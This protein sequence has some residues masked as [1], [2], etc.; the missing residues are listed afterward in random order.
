MPRSENQKLKLLYLAKILLYETDDEHPLTMRK[1]LAELKKNDITAE[2]RSIYGDL[3]ALRRFGLDIEIHKA[4]TT[5]YYIANRKFELPELKLLADA[6]AS[7]QFITPKKSHALIG[8][9]ET[10]TSI[11][12]AKQLQRQVY[13]TGRAKTFNEQIYYNVNAI[14][15]AIADN[16]Q[17]GFQ[18]FEYAVDSNAPAK[19]KKQYRFGGE[20]YLASP[21]ALVWDDENYYMLAFNE[22]FDSLHHYRVD[23]MEKVD[24]MKVA[25]QPLSKGAEFDPAEYAKKVFNMFGGKEEKFKLRFNN[26]L[27]G[28]VLDRFGKDITIRPDG[29]DGFTINVDAQISPML[30]AWIFGFGDK[31]KILEPDNLA[32]K[33]KEQAAN[34]LK[35]Y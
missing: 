13:I 34:I 15:R 4:K 10:L 30:L 6:V 12:E 14:H 16:R 35:L 22:K 1:I 19:W 17:I 29:N 20:Q 11:H 25:R 24:V 23:K 7:S 32:Q 28:V 9:I 27:I 5:G 3:E 21:Y 2:R 8:K 31:V 18:Y 26:S 33:F